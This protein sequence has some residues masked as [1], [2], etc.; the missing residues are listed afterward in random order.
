M[1]DTATE[2]FICPECDRELAGK[3]SLERHRESQHGVARATPPRTA[4]GEPRKTRGPAK[5]QSDLAKAHFGVSTLVVGF[6]NAPVLARIEVVDLLQKQ[7]EEWSAAMHA[8]ARQDERIMRT[9]ES[10]MRAGVWAAFFAQTAS[11]VLTLGVL[12]GRVQVPYGIVLAATPD[13]AKLMVQ[14]QPAAPTGSNGT[15]PT[16]A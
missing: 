16:P 3:A 11:S 10:A 7:S 2:P 15:E 5:L 9:I 6:T 14:E 12:S 13:L 1:S 4:S 8:V